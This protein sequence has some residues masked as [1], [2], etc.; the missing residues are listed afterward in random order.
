MERA[1]KRTTMSVPP[2]TSIRG[3][4]TDAPSVS[5]SSSMRSPNFPVCAA[6][7]MIRQSWLSFHAGAFSSN[8]A[9]GNCSAVSAARAPQRSMVKSCRRFMMIQPLYLHNGIRMVAMD[10]FLQNL[11]R[12][13]N[14]SR[15]TGEKTSVIISCIMKE[16]ALFHLTAPCLGRGATPDERTVCQIR[17]KKS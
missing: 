4:K 8:P 9:F 2:A 11:R 10:V 7:G 12:I 16:P 6:S 14:T 13:F 5:R 17:R 15:N 1:Q 3:A